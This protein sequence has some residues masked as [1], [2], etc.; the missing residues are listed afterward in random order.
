M[1]TFG[2]RYG[3][4]YVARWP[5]DV[6]NRLGMTYLDF[7]MALSRVLPN[8]PL[9]WGWVG[10]VEGDIAQESLIPSLAAH[11]MDAMED[12]VRAVLAQDA[13]ADLMLNGGLPNDDY[14]RSCLGCDGS[15]CAECEE[16]ETD[17]R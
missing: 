7:A 10:R 11:P 12:L 14:F 3:D 9:D 1:Q 8:P 17:D 16:G 13:V 6:C 2:E 5:K 15:G 4:D